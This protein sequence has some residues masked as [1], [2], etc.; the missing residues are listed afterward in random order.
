MV[1]LLTSP[2]AAL[3]WQDYLGLTPEEAARTA[4]WGI[5]RLA[6]SRG[7]APQPANAAADQSDLA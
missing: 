3:Y 1:L 7:T 2:L 6:A 5:R 4:A